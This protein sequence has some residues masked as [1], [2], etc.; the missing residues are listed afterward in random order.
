MEL[1]ARWSHEE[2]PEKPQA[3]ES[4]QTFPT[5]YIPLSAEVAMNWE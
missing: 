3:L 2:Y 5:W 4:H 1:P